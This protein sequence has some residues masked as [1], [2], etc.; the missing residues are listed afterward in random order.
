M[1][2]STPTPEPDPEPTVTPP[3]SAAPPARQRIPFTPIPVVEAPPPVYSP[4][5]PT[6]P[7]VVVEDVPPPYSPKQV[8]STTVPETRRGRLGMKEGT[9]CGIKTVNLVA[10]LALLIVAAVITG[11]VYGYQNR[12]SSS[13][14][15]DDDSSDENTVFAAPGQSVTG[16]DYY[17]GGMGLVGE[18]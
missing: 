10:L 8:R 18:K 1:S 7:F 13:S 15:D 9:I 6:V 5:A 4:A 12:S 2:N 11:G 3:V 16:S 14:D 17:G